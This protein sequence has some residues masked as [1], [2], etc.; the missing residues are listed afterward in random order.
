MQQMK[1]HYFIL[2]AC[3]L[4]TSN[5]FSQRNPITTAVPFLLIAP[6]ARGGSMG[7]AGVSSTPDVY[8]MFWNPAKYAF[9]EKGRHRDGEGQRHPST[10]D[11]GE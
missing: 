6:D 4:F 2:L 8:S 10:R 9:C 7:D 3:I 1:I 11:G 5:V